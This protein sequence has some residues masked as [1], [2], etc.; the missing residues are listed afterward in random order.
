MVISATVRVVKAGTRPGAARRDVTG[1][2]RRPP[3]PQPESGAE[4]LGVRRDR[5][6]VPSSPG[7]VCPQALQASPFASSTRP[8]S[9]GHGPAGDIEGCRARVTEASIRGRQGRGGG[10]ETAAG[11]AE[12]PAAEQM[13]ARRRGRVACRVPSREGRPRMIPR[14][15]EQAASQ[16][17]GVEVSHAHCDITSRGV[18]GYLGAAGAGGHHRSFVAR[19]RALAALRPRRPIVRERLRSLPVPLQR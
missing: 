6:Q 17:V 16:Y 9:R 10:G 1:R 7:S 19:R 5:E 14:T 13:E 18:G 4:R 12:K 2:G 15:R 11:A 3:V 8:S